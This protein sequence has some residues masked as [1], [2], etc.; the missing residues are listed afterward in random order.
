M[1]RKRMVRRISVISLLW[2]LSVNATDD[3]ESWKQQEQADFQN[4]LSEQDKAFVKFLEKQW[5]AVPTQAPSELD[6]SPKPVDVPV[7]PEPTKPTVVVKPK[8]QVTEKPVVKPPKP[9]QPPKPKPP[10][11]K[12]P[13]VDLAKG[14]SIK[15]FFYGHSLAYAYDRALKVSSMPQASDRGITGYYTQLA[16]TPHQ[17]LVNDLQK[18]QKALRLNDWSYALLVSRVAENIQPRAKRQ[19]VLLTWFLLLKSGYQA[20]IAYDAQGVYL[21]LP[22]AQ[23]LFGVMYFTLEGKPYY[24]LDFAHLVKGQVTTPGRRLYTYEGQYPNASRRFDLSKASDLSWIPEDRSA[25][26][27]KL[28]FSYQNQSYSM[29]YQYSKEWVEYLNTLPQMDLPF[30]F[31]AGMPTSV[32]EAMR[33]DLAPKIKGMGQV[34]AVNF[35]LR[36]VQKAFPYQT[37]GQQF[38]RENYLYPVETLHYPYS[39]CEDRSALFSWLVQEL[40]GLDVVILDYPGHVATAVA[41]TEK[42]QGDQIRHRGKVYW[43]ADPTYMNA[44]VGQAMPKFRHQAPK[45]LGVT[46]I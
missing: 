4:Y 16:R 23:K 15:F 44:G 17:S 11:P 35:L 14:T 30:Y 10:T 39:D 20:R 12:P 43:V 3:F 41:L 34:E 40:M 25:T 6:K 38:K 31:Q 42:G 7:A 21:M 19:Q 26:A 18:T 37:D 1:K 28:Q 27:R 32:K 29:S 2:S 8:P 36:F 45:V 13:R 33:A 24:V 9:V 46:S 22:T 5:Q